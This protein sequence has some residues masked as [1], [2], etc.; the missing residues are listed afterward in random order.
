MWNKGFSIRPVTAEDRESF[1]RMSR[2]FYASPAVLHDIPAE[3]HDRAFDELMAQS[4]YAAGFII[5]LDNKT[6]GYALLSLSY[7]REA[8]GRVVWIEELYVLPEF[9]GQGAAHFFFDWLERQ[10]PA[11]R[12]RLET[13]H[14]NHRAKKL[15]TSLG[16]KALDYE[17]LIKGE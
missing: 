7:S 16:Y 10:Y 9:Q 8:G 2:D 14:D 5:S 13:E 3:Y 1:V 12:Y 17:Q 15:Y 11:A 4:P 6:A